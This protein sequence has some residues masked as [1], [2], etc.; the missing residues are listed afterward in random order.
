MRQ[1]DK[2]RM[3]AHIEAALEKLLGVCD[4]PTLSEPGRACYTCN[5]LQQD[6]IVL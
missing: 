3:I 5:K 6:A 4:A 1:S 2:Q